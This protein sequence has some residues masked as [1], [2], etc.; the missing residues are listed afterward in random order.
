MF[1]AALDRLREG[2]LVCVFDATDRIQHMFWRYLDPDIRPPADASRPRTRTPSASCTATTTRWSGAVRAQ[3]TEG[4]VLMV[5]SD[6]GFSS[7]RRGVNLNAWLLREGYLTL[8]HGA[9]GSAEWLR[10][11]DWARTRAYCLGLTGMFLNLRGPRGRGHRQSRAPRRPRSR[12]R[13]SAKL[14]GLQDEERSATSASTR[15]STRRRSTTVR[16]SRTRPTSSSATTPA[17]ASRG[18]APRHG[19]G[20]GVRG[21]H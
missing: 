18:T 4:D 6:H 9:D 2:A 17:T 13:S 5:I 7:F 21:Q 16:T 11:V 1:F 12:P 3:L 20:A 15:S 10:D 14:R 19:V 8:K